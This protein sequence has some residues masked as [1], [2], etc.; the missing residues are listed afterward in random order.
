MCKEEVTRKK[1]PVVL[2][3]FVL[4]IIMI[5]LSDIVENITIQNRSIGIVTNPIFAIIMVSI[6]AIEILKCRTK[7]K[8]SI[9]S[10]QFIIHKIK[11][12]TRVQIVVENIKLKDIGSIVKKGKF[13][14][15]FDINNKYTCSFFNPITYCC[16]Y[17]CNGK[18]KKFY[19]QPSE[20]FVTKLCSLVEE[21]KNKAS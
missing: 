3:Y 21:E 20:K 8:Y 17:T 10:D 16:T 11:T 7:Y 1:L 18:D 4:L 2:S 19:F 13:N 14:S 6:I 5:C 9:I 15:R 12:N